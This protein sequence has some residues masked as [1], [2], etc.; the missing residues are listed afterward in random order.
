MASIAADPVAAGS[1]NNHLTGLTASITKPGGLG[2]IPLKRSQACI[3]NCMVTVLPA[4]G[5]GYNGV[6][7]ATHTFAGVA[8]ETVTGAA[9]AD[10]TPIKVWRKGLFWFTLASGAA[11]DLN[12]LALLVYNATVQT[13]ATTASIVVGKIVAMNADFSLALVDIGDRVA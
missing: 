4:E 9:A 13:G 6:D 3:K 12:K 7:T 1:W 8:A 5:F 10:T 11:T 2:A